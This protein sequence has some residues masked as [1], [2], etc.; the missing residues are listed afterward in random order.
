MIFQILMFTI[1]VVILMLIQA[2]IN[3]YI[4]IYIYVTG[5]LWNQGICRYPKQFR[6]SVDTLKMF[7]VSTDTLEFGFKNSTDTLK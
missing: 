2:F 6:V 3:I 1:H 5:Y 4:Y 7:R